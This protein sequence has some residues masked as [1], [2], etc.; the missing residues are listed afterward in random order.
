MGQSTP[1]FSLRLRQIA[2]LLMTVCITILS[3][4]HTH[5]FLQHYTG[6]YQAWLA[7]KAQDCSESHNSPLNAVMV[8]DSTILYSW[9]VVTMVETSSLPVSGGAWRMCFFSFCQPQGRERTK[10]V[11]LPCHGFPEERCRPTLMCTQTLIRAH[12]AWPAERCCD[13]NNLTTNSEVMD[14]DFSVQ[15]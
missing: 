8:S 2:S 3:W 4:Q 1:F 9:C 11:D 13:D 5:L 7:L 14:Y 10:P 12:P 15:R 6:G